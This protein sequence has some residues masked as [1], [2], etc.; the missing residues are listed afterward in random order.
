MRVRQTVIDTSDLDRRQTVDRL[1]QIREDKT[2]DR[3]HENYYIPQGILPIDYLNISDS[4]KAIA[5]LANAE[6]ILSQFQ[7]KMEQV[8]KRT[9][10]ATFRPFPELAETEKLHSIKHIRQ[11]IRNGQFHEAVAETQRLISVALQGLRYYQTYDRFFLGASIVLGFLGW[12]SYTFILL[13][14]EHTNVGLTRTASLQRNNMTA[15][16]FVSIG[17]I[18]AVLLYV[19]S[20]PFMCY[21]YC[22]LPVLLWYKFFEGWSL[23]A[24]AVHTTVDNHYIW[25]ITTSLIFCAAGLE[26]VILSFYYRKLLSV[27][28]LALSTWPVVTFYWDGK[29]PG[30][31]LSSVGWTL[32]SLLVAIFPLL[33]IVSKDTQYHLVLAS[34]LFTVL[35]SLI[36]MFKFFANVKASLRYLWLLQLALVGWSIIIVKLTSDSIISGK[37][38]PLT[39]QLSSWFILGCSLL[40]SMLSPTTLYYRLFSL[41]LSFFAPYLLLSITY[42][43]LFLLSVSS[44]L[45]FWLQLEFE[46]SER[47]T[48]PHF[49]QIDFKDDGL[50]KENLASPTFSRYLELADLRRAFFFIFFMLTAFFGTGNI[51]S[52]NSFDPASVYC[53]LTVFS[54]FLMGSLMIFKILIPFLAVTCAFRA[55]HV[56]TLTPLRSLFLIVLIMSDFMGLHFFFLVKDYGSWL[57]IG[58]T[59]SHYVIVMLL[60]IFLLVLT[61]LSHGLTCWTFSW[62]KKGEKLS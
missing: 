62:M 18:I 12:M 14:S 21:I 33:P 7:V 30:R 56:I 23:L 51:A 55:I 59:I 3:L 47:S 44:L 4:D 57:D 15:Y 53:F 19:Q 6:Q 26:I 41:S 45:Y 20:L 38:L 2:V 36:L 52:I 42:E 11:L 37:G 9:I 8:K 13:V 48:Q 46:A 10:S 54:P 24:H 28:L 31:L 60:N 25:D 50:V 58:T 5:L 1:H 16:I 43:G 35:I 40:L 61:G 34:G 29:L 17:I 32:S 49:E 27:G 39:C 22:L